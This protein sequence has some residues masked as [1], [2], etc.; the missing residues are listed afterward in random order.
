MATYRQTNLHSHRTF[1]SASNDNDL[2]LPLSKEVLAGKGNSPMELFKKAVIPAAL[3]S[4]FI[5]FHQQPAAAVSAI[6]SISTTVSQKASSSGFLQAFLLIFISELGD[7]T[8]FIAG[9]LAAKYNKFISF[10]GSIGALGAMTILC[11]ILGQIFHAVPSSI[12]QGIPFDDYIAVAA[13]SYFGLKTLKDAI[14]LDPEDS[15]GIE[16]EKEEA[17][18]TVAEI[19][20]ER[21]SGIALILQVFSLVFAAE[22]G[23]RSFLAT[24]ALSAAQNPFS[25]A[26][27]AIAAHATATGIA[28]IGGAL[29][30]KY[31]SEKTIGFIGGSLFLLFAVTTAIGVF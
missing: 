30:S 9:L 11:T 4:S 22:I 26:T 21:R 12:S 27:G 3:V 16:E 13:F 5:F 28:V 18:K 17:E 6:E 29:M 15:S 25:V 2:N 1:L 8:F 31:L 23:D 19:N 10:T 14:E 20:E 7:K 24:I